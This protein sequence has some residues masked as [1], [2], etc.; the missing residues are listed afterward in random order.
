MKKKWLSLLLTFCMLLS[1]LPTAA[2]A[3]GAFG[4][5]DMPAEGTWSYDALTSAVE[6]GLLQGNNGKLMPKGNL[7]RA[8][9]A[10]ILN[11]AF[12]A[13]SKADVSR[14]TDVK[15]T[16]WYYNDIAKAVQMGTFQGG[17]N[18]TMR[19]N[20]PIS[21]QEAFTVLAR[22]FK[23]ADGNASALDGFADK[24]SV[25]AYAQSPLAAMVQAGYVGGAG[26]RLLPVSPVTREQFAQVLY[27]MLNTYI[28]AAGTYTESVTG[29]VMVNTP[30]VVLKNLSITGDLLLGEGVGDGDVTLNNVKLTGRLVV[31]GGGEHSIVLTN[32]TTVGSVILGKT[33][34]GGVR[35]RTEEGCRV[36]VVHVDDGR[37]DVILEGSFNQ[38]EIATDAPVVLSKATVTGLT[39]A[40]ENAR[41]TAGAGTTISA[42]Q[43]TPA[44]A[45]TALTVES[46][47]KIATVESTATGVTIAGGGTVAQATV[48]GNNTAV[49]TTG[50]KVTAAEGV[51]GV[52]QN[53]TEVKPTVPPTTTTTGSGGGGGTSAPTS[54][55]VTTSDQLIAAIKNPQYTKI[56]LGSRDSTLDQSFTIPGGE[57]LTLGA[58]RELYVMQNSYGNPTKLTIETGASLQ[59]NGYLLVDGYVCNK[60]TLTV[61]S[62]M[63]IGNEGIIE[64]RSSFTVGSPCFLY[65]NRGLVVNGGTY[66]CNASG[67]KIIPG[68][69]KAYAASATLPTDGTATLLTADVAL[70]GNQ[71]LAGDLFIPMGV[72]VATGA[73]TLTVNADVHLAGTLVADDGTVA[74]NSGKTITITSAT[75]SGNGTLTL[76]DTGTGTLTNNGSIRLLHA[77]LFAP[78]GTVTNSGDIFL[79][80]YGG[81]IVVGDIGGTHAYLSQ[82]YLEVSA[83]AELQQAMADGAAAE[84]TEDITLNSDL[85]VTRP[86]QIDKDKTLTVAAGKSLTLTD[87]AGMVLLGTLVNNGTFT[88]GADGDGI[89]AD[90][91]SVITNS[92]NFNNNN[93]LGIFEGTFTNSGTLNIN[94]VPGQENEGA[95]HI[96]L[97]GGTFTNATGGTVNNEKNFWC[98]GSEGEPGKET[99]ISNA[100][101]F[102]NGSISLS[103]SDAQ[104]SME[105]GSLTN[106]GRFVNNG[107]IDLNGVA[108]SH[109]GTGAT[110][111]TYNSSGLQLTGGS[112]DVSSAAANSFTNN[113]YMKIVDKY[114]DTNSICTIT[115][116]SGKQAFSNNSNWLDY[117]AAVYSDAGLTAAEAAQSSKKTTLSTSESYYGTSVYNRLD[118]KASF[119]VSSSKTL[120]AFDMYWVEGDWSWNDNEEKDVLTPYTLTVASGKTLT[121][122]QKCALHISD[123]ALVVNGTLIVA[124][125][126]DEDGQDYVD[127]G[128]V[129]IW[130]DASFTNSGTVTNNGEFLIRYI[131]DDNIPGAFT[132]KADS[133]TL[134][135]VSV[136]S[137]EYLAIVHTAA[138]LKAANV[139][140]SPAFGRLEIKDNSNLTP[141]ETMTITKKI[142]IEPGSGLVIP[143]GMTL[144]LGNGET[145]LWCDNDGD[146]SVYGELIITDSYHFTNRKKLEIGAVSGGETA[147]MTVSGE[148]ENQG[149]II[150]YS[151]GTL[152]A[153]GGSYNGNT[154][155]VNGSGTYTAPAPT[156]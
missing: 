15:A 31:R 93:H 82:E 28:R 125:P 44:A 69:V 5:S 140:T 26:G 25:S 136:N 64:N 152:D 55:T 72:T 59:I 75:Q 29:N 41:V 132:R 22:A 146:V 19:P 126:T 36:E 144:T 96:M 108:L 80:V 45:S 54:I 39:I 40:A 92:G 1:L 58:F 73:H 62:A 145:D 149:D 52:T 114:G 111:Q 102:N 42:T 79:P 105:G 50:T 109:G 154:P 16:A 95:A 104:L 6:N 99:T 78:R 103:S 134:G 148:L 128:R 122:G 57:N 156:T 63:E 7:T 12:G 142:Y 88:N 8:Q 90:S 35:L 147:T 49:N 71:T 135:T 24:A 137:V 139:S 65:T 85:T 110:F 121:V 32:K 67:D 68:T 43:I 150:I 119:T 87:G 23:L 131:E 37:D 141:P 61:G 46:G 48:S 117:T 10:A 130:P 21:R 38:V 143:H 153:S 89:V 53:G 127:G 138:G 70:T 47:A 118:F 4:F 60:G 115:L 120:S 107:N 9:L 101:T 106:T 83:E 84:I 74:V 14:F 30:D 124:A 2:V 86:M 33:G 13:V 98:S 100:G 94:S 112:F 34:D 77:M 151:T 133:V 18:N 51:T 91:L 113:G 123:G 66:A 81:G 3:V 27:K 17:V 116:D 76:G 155:T 20:D 56:W 97:V 11:R 129:E